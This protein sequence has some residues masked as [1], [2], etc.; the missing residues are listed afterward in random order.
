M[1]PGRYKYVDEE[2]KIPHGKKI[3]ATSNTT[4]KMMKPRVHTLEKV[5]LISSARFKKQRKTTLK[6]KRK[7]SIKKRST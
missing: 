2:V 5:N 6:G 1:P 7:S 4:P 3:E